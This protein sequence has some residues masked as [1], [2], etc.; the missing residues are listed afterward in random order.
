MDNFR[1]E[2]IVRRN[3]TP[4]QLLYMLS[5]VGIV[6]FGLIALM[7]LQTTVMQMNFDLVSIAILLVSGGIAALLFF[8]KDNLKVEYEYTFTNGD[9]DFARVLSN[10][11]RKELGTMKVKNVEAC[12]F[13]THPSF[14]RYLTMKDVRKDNWFLNRGANLF[15]FFFQKDGKKRLIV[16]EPSAEMAKL[17]KQYAAMSAY[18]G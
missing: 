4:Y 14:Q 2:I 3:A 16:I 12:G 10:S 17:V 9:L 8:K 5:W 11:K 13:V 7:L 1:E 15:Y 18:Q 6:L